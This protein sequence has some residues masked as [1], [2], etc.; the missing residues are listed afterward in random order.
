M[1]IAHVTAP[2][3]FGGLERVVSGLARGQRARGHE[4]MVIAVIS[5]GVAIPP[6]VPALADAGVRVEV[7][8]VG[9]RAYFAERRLVRRLLQEMRADVVHTHG[10][11]S[12][13][14]HL[15]VA[16]GLGMPV[17]STAHGFASQRPG[18]SLHEKIQV[19]AWRRVDRVVAVSEPLQQHLIR[20][21][22]PAARIA[23]I[24][25]GFVGSPGSLT[26][27]EARRELG[28][29][30]DAPVIGWVGRMSGEKDPMLAVEVLAALAAPHAHLCFIGDGP[31]RAACEA[32]AAALGLGGRL[33]AS[34]ARPEAARF[35]AA[36]DVL[37]LS[38]QTEGTPMTILEAAM[39]GVPIVSTSVGGVPDV[40]REDGALV[41]HG[42]AALLAA[43]VRGAIENPA[44]AARKSDRLRTRLMREEAM[45]DWVGSYEALY[46]SL[47]ANPS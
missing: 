33:R 21:G 43:A 38:S 25:N 47:I 17:V 24:R 1:R 27:E 28:L 41:P 5:P 42:D 3:Q 39:A 14:L 46:R 40:V 29:P 2:A 45:D 13:V 18:L 9:N 22:V 35:L 6:W 11:R 19:Y 10:Y 37:L 7:H 36:F 12:D 23:Q 31:L 20:L 8:H 34:G 4:V 44:E 16:H 30:S 26:R 32:R 15:S